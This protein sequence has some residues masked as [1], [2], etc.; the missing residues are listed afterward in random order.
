M[1]KSFPLKRVIGNFTDRTAFRALCV[2]QSVSSAQPRV[3]IRLIFFELLLH[4]AYRY[5]EF[6]TRLR[7]KAP[8][9]FL[10]FSRQDIFHGQ[11][12]VGLAEGH[13]RGEQ[14]GADH[15]NE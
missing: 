10:R 13:G 5:L 9:I 3:G 8:R 7:E 2:A 4:Q 14:D 6:E 15:D 11:D 1:G 12:G